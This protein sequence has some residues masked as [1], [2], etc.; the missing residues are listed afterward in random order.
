[1]NNELYPALTRFME[2][3][4]LHASLTRNNLQRDAFDQY[5][6]LLTSQQQDREL[7]KEL[8][9]VARL[10]GAVDNAKSAHDY[11]RIIAAIAHQKAN[12][13]LKEM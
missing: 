7:I 11:L 9:E 12:Q 4:F 5:Q 2:Q 3:T 8:N 6:S 13:R 1:M 10:V